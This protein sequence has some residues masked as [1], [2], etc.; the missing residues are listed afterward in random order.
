[1]AYL[2]LLLFISSNVILWG[3]HIFALT[4]WYSMNIGE[5]IVTECTHFSVNLSI[6]HVNAVVQI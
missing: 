6:S 5:N 2:L 4:Y 3:A 1:M